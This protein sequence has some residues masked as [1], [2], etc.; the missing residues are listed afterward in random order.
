MDFNELSS[1]VINLADSADLI[2][3]NSSTDI[4]DLSKDEVE[5]NREALLADANDLSSFVSAISK[6]HVDTAEQ[7]ELTIG[8]QILYAIVQAEKQNLDVLDA[9]NKAVLLFEDSQNNAS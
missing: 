3:Q 7:I 5:K 9:L 6:S 8:G 2:D 4:L 1:R